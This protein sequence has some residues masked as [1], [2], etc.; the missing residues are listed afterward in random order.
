MK[1]LPV[2]ALVG[3]VN[4][5]KSTLFNRLIEE[6]K[7]L[8]ST[9]PGTTRTP[10][11]GVVLWR[12]KTVRLIDTGGVTFRDAIPLEEDI[13]LQTERAMREA[14]LIVFVADAETGIVADD[15]EFAK[16]LQ[17]TKKPVILVANKAD[18]GRD[19]TNLTDRE[20]YSLGFNAPIPLSAASGRRV[21]DFLDVVYTALGKSKRRPKVYAEEAPDIRVAI[22]GKPNVGKSS[23]FNKLIGEEKVIVSPMAHTTREPHDTRVMYEKTPI[24]FIDTAGIRRKA[25]VSGELEQKGIAKSLQTVSASDIVLLVLDGTDTISSQDLQLGGLLAKHAKS[26]LILVNKWDLATDVSDTKRNDVKRMIYSYF[27]HLDFAPIIFVSGKTG[28]RVHQIFPELLHAWRARQTEIPP[29]TLET[30]L[31]SA[32]R[33]HRP[34]RGKGTHHPKLLRLRQLDVNPPVFE[35]AVKLK[36]SIHSS[37][38]QYLER[39]MREQFDFYATPLI[40]KLTKMKR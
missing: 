3:R 15:R 28:Y 16:A 38:V 19:E 39:K 29:E 14:D 4:V 7:A 22:I 27:P 23:L 40:I 2:V 30:F 35:V 25:K 20:W 37:Y 13:R 9:I 31:R 26:V 21:G 6:Q 17:K 33:E 34:S 5:G 36:T 8:V 24:T 12:G 32:T 18:R 11:E 10:N 1:E